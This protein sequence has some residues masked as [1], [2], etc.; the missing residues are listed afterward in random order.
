M[1][2]PKIQEKEVFGSGKNEKDGYRFLV[3]ILSDARMK[4]LFHIKKERKK[5]NEIRNF[6]SVMHRNQQEFDVEIK[7]VLSRVQR[8][9]AK[10]L[11]DAINKAMDKVLE[12]MRTMY[13]Y[14]CYT[15]SGYLH[16]AD[17]SISN[18]ELKNDV[19][20]FPQ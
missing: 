3:S 20:C 13:Q 10:S 16:G 4:R 11:D 19:F 6:Y 1:A 5:R 7:E 14:C 8:V 15:T 2:P 17:C 9:K 12:S 18:V